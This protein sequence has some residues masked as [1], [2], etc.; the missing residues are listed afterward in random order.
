[1]RYRPLG[2]S[3]CKVSV[4]GLGS[5]LT[6]G[7][8]VDQR[9]TTQLVRAALDAGINFLDTADIYAK[10][11]AERALGKALQGV[12]RQDLVLASKCFWPM[13]DNVNDR[14]LSRKHLVESC[15]A[16]LQR[17]GTDYLD[18]FQCHRPDPETPV[19]ET[20]RAMEDLV[21]QGKVLYWG[22]SVWD[23]AQIGAACA[24]ADRCG[25]YHPVSNQPEYSYV[26]RGIEDEVVPACRSLG[27]SQVVWS[28]LAQGL[29]TGKYAGGRIPPGSRGADE[30]RNKFL[31]PLLSPDNLAKAAHLAA[32]ARDLG[33][34]PAQLA[35]AWVLAQPNISSAI[36]GATRIE[37]LQENLGAADVALAPE[38]LE[39]LGLVPAA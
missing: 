21:R 17:L 11:E 16:S 18:L 24:A 30:Q 14:G 10:G 38:V 3:G 28:P 15:H 6:L 36:M 2:R 27:L 39:R 32:V 34:T 31:R 5:W 12:R 23:A 29:L 8:S 26:Q 7:S 35:L 13:S 22:V 25:G 37:Q 9:V 33:L 19:E 4:L 20:V 1:M